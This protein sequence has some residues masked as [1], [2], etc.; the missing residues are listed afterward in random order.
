MFQF[1]IEEFN[2]KNIEE[3]ETEKNLKTVDED[4]EWK[5]IIYNL[6]PAKVIYNY[7]YN[8]ELSFCTFEMYYKSLKYN[9][10]TIYN[11]IMDSK[12]FEEG[13]G[14][15]FKIGDIV[16]IKSND[17]DYKFYDKLH[18]VKSIPY[19]NQKYFENFYTVTTNDDNGCSEI[20]VR[21]EELELYKHE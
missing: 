1:C 18:I 6:E 3:L 10:L 5:E 7:N 12:D 20:N 9:K 17:I 8:G 4:G 19:K 15:K 21:E 13:A 11:L 2:P 14:E 16:K